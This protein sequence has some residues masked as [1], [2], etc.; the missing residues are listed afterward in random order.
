MKMYGNRN[1]VRTLEADAI[2]LGRLCAEAALW[3]RGRPESFRGGQGYRS[4]R[5]ETFSFLEIGLQK[6]LNRKRNALGITWGNVLMILIPRP[7]GIRPSRERGP[8]SRLAKPVS[9]SYNQVRTSAQS[10]GHHS[11][12]WP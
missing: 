11:Q 3:V 12:L 6:G 7:S 8:G 5:L 10:M 2:A 4:T 1:M 9:K